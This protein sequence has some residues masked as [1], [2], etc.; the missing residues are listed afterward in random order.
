M[1]KTGWVDGQPNVHVC[2]C[3]VGRY[4][5]LCPGGHILNLFNEIKNVKFWIAYIKALEIQKLQYSFVSIRTKCSFWVGGVHSF[6]STW[7]KG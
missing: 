6:G 7:T 5:I 1:D 3:K 4:C 2:P